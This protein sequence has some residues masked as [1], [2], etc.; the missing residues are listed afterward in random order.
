MLCEAKTCCSPSGRGPRVR[1]GGFFAI[2]KTLDKCT[3]IVNLVPVNRAMPEKPEK[4]S[5]LSMDWPCW[6]TWRSRVHHSSYP[7]SMVRPGV[8]GWSVRC[9]GSQ[10][11]GDEELCMCHGV[12]R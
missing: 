9:S 5:F 8:S 3:V 10:G 2:P 4:V 11:G 6:R 12:R 7:P 1:T